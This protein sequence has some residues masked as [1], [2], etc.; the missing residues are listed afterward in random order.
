MS[1]GLVVAEGRASLS[2]STGGGGGGLRLK[3]PRD[4]DSVLHVS[5]LSKCCLSPEAAVK[6]LLQFL[7][8]NGFVPSWVLVCSSSSLLEVNPLPQEET[9]LAD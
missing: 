7:Q 1:T 4:S 5:Y 8:T 6:V 3:V 9:F 2:F